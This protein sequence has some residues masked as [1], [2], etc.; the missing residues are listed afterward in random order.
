MLINDPSAIAFCNEQI[1][2]LCNRVRDTLIL[3]A[4]A[5]AQWATVSVL[6][7]NDATSIDDGRTDGSPSITGADVNAAMAAFAALVPANSDAINK[8]CNQAP[9]SLE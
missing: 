5:Q 7:P 4:A 2:P 9:L 8:P 6:F 1:R 3:L